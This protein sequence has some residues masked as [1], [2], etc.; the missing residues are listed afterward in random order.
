MTPKPPSSLSAT[1]PDAGQCLDEG[2]AASGAGDSRRATEL[3]SQAQTLAPG[4][5]LPAFLLG[6]EYAALGDFERAEALFAQ[7]VLLAPDFHIARYQL[8]LLQFSSGRTQLAMLTW[9]PLASPSEEEPYAHLV[10]G[11]GALALG[12]LGAARHYLEAGLPLAGSNQGLVDDIRRVLAALEEQANSV[13][14][15]VPARSSADKSDDANQNH[16]L[17][18]NYSQGTVH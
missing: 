5:H 10:Q 6:S 15:E 14:C 11:F 7:T 8:G 2:L 1:L 4:W 13:N 16:V 12:D 18:S 3:F 17:L 9:A